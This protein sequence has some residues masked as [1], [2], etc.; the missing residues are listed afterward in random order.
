MMGPFF[1]AWRGLFANEESMAN[2]K[3]TLIE[4]EKTFI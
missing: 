2:L 4:V 3:K 1:G